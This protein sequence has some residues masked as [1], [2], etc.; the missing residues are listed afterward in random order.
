M[1]NIEIVQALEPNGD[2][3]E[4]L[5]DETLLKKLFIFLLDQYLLIQV[6]IIRKIHHYT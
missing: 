1:Q 2:L 6:S 3:N 4:G 5:P